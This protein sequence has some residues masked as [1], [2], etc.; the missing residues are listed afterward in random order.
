MI[1]IYDIHI[2]ILYDIIYIYM[3]Y[4]LFIYIY[5]HCVLFMYSTIR[6]AAI[7]VHEPVETC[8][9]NHEGMTKA[10]HAACN[11]NQAYSAMMKTFYGFL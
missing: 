11:L 6:C 3:K 8:V 4:I 2:Y 5:I 10:P 9:S 7:T 1:Y